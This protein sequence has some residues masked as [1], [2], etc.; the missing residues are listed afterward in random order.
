MTRSDELIARFNDSLVKLCFYNEYF[1]TQ[2]KQ[3]FLDLLEEYKIL[4]QQN[5]NLEKAVHGLAKQVEK[6]DNLL[7]EVKHENTIDFNH[8]SDSSRLP[9]QR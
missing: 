2:I 7:H 5:L 9:L 4:L 3:P 6:L 1:Y 8:A